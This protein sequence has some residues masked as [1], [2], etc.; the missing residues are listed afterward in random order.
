MC[1]IQHYYTETFDKIFK[2]NN[3]IDVISTPTTV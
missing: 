2:L 3:F 1:L